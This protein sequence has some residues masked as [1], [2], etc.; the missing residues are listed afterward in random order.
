MPYSKALVL[1]VEDDS[2]V[3]RQIRHELEKAFANIRVEIAG[4][5]PK[6]HTICERFK[7]DLIFWEG[8][9]HQHGTR[10]EFLDCIPADQW[11]N[12]VPISADQECLREAKERGALSPHAKQE[13][14]IH[15]WCEELVRVVK[16]TFPP[17]K[18]KKKK[19]KV[20]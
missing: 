16:K 17:P 2:R 15:H 19:K 20:A 6:A 11:K 13:G 14:H 4:S 7:P 12:V 10:Q 3:S 5:P 9:P 1:I 8:I 18:K